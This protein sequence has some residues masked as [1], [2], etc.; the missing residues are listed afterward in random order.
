MIEPDVLGLWLH[1]HETDFYPVVDFDAA[2]QKI[3]KLDLSPGN[4]NFGVKDYETTAALNSFIEKEKEKFGAT[5]LI[6]GYNE[7]RNM[8]LRSALFDSNL[9]PDLVAAEE[10]RNIHLGVDIWGAVHTKIYA[11]LDGVI[12]SFAFNNNFGDYG[13]TIILQHQIKNGNFYS[14]YGHL[15]LQDIE[16]IKTGQKI[17]RGEQ[18]AHFGAPNENGDW[19]PHLHFQLILNINNNKGDYAGVCKQSEAAF[20]LQ[21]CPNPDVI[22]KLNRFL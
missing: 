1:S 5:Y 14:L 17:C 3:A 2:N 12:H 15:A 11:P 13:A 8:Y 22:L 10:P 9:Q 18:F 19:P 6:G 7:L 4:T 20:Y 21:N 16:Q